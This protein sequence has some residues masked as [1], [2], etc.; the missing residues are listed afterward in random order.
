MKNKLF[1]T[2][3]LIASLL[4]GGCGKKKEAKTEIATPEVVAV[5]PVR[6]SIQDLYSATGSLESMQ[7]IELASEV[8][9]KI[10]KL[11]ADEGQRVSKGMLIV[12][13]DDSQQRAQLAQT[14]ANLAQ[15]K[16]ALD[17]IKTGARPQE[18]SQSEQSVFEAK[19]NHDLAQT[20]YKRVK[21]MYDQGVASKQELDSSENTLK[22][23]KSAL[24]QAEQ[25]LSLTREGAR[26]EDRVAAEAT[27][28]QMKA[29][30]DYNRVLLSKTKIVSPVDGVVTA[31]Y[32][33][34]GNMVTS[35][36]ITPILRIEQVN[37]I[38]AV[39]KVPQEDQFKIKMGQNVFLKLEDGSSYEGAVSLV[40][41]A[42]DQANRSVKVEAK[43]QN[44]KGIFKPGLFVEG[45]IL[46]QTKQ[47]VLTVPKEAVIRQS[48]DNTYRVFA[49]RDGIAK[50]VPVTVGITE[51]GHIEIVTGIT[52]QDQVITIG[53]EKF[54]DGDKVKVA[55]TK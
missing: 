9:G 27:V 37:P 52:D 48:S 3:I 20:N 14:E 55:A 15:A 8:T 36:Q 30:V 1:I 25:A 32:K 6:Q 11:Y 46:L 44:T 17:K 18:L 54:S 26:K 22:I 12:D 43:L 13:I 21:N 4:I 23:T 47:S 40:S 2:G 39:L 45:K 41:P 24:S 42:V 33:Q 34:V 49:I 28:D 31:R 19:S 38:K 5:K 16:A 35:G 53:F 51:D 7:V 29:L 10:K 50:K